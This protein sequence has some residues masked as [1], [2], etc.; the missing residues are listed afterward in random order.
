MPGYRRQVE[1]D[2]RRKRC[3]IFGDYLIGIRT[4]FLEAMA[5]LEDAGQDSGYRQA[6][7]LGLLRVRLQFAAAMIPANLRLFQYRWKLTPCH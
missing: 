7:S 1:I 6:N 3:Q 4:E 5:E 2:F